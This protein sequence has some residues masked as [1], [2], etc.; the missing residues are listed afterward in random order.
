MS[1]LE[2]PLLH[3]VLW[4]TGDLLLRA[5]LDLQLKDKAGL[6]RPQNFL[7]DSGTEMTTM[8]AYDARLLDL[9]MPPAPAPGTVHAQTGLAFFSGL[10]RVRVVGMDLTEYTFPC[11]FL[12]DLGTPPGGKLPPAPP[13]A[14]S[15]CPGS[16]TG[17]D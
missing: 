16:S 15:G 11:F 5:E 17:S 14:S 9:P 1:R 13:D 4:S 10:L 2:V 12:G 7:V 3:R 8:P 6:W